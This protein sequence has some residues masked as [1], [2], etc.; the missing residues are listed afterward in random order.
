MLT[1]VPLTARLS[2]M[3]MP[4]FGPWADDTMVRT[5]VAVITTPPTV[6]FKLVT[7]ADESTS[8]DQLMVAE[9][10]V[11][12]VSIDGTL[13][14]SC[15]ASRASLAPPRDPVSDTVVV[16]AVPPDPRLVACTARALPVTDGELVFDDVGCSLPGTAKLTGGQTSRPTSIAASAADAEHRWFRRSISTSLR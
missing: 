5:E 7:D 16:V 11:S 1:G 12:A 13:A 10:G 9:E 14:V 3:V 2:I 6:T 4:L 8:F 15:E